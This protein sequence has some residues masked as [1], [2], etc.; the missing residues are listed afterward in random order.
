[1]F[2]IS[3][4]DLVIAQCKAGVIGAFPSLN[5]RPDAVLDEWL[6]RIERELAEHDARASRTALRAVRREP[7][8]AQ[9]EPAAGC[10]ISTLA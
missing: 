9:D 5:A 6:E 3:Q 4:P 10:T 7:D 8:R 2:I 1:M